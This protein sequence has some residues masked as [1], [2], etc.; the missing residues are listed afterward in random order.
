MIFD[1]VNKIDNKK[2]EAWTTTTPH[3]IAKRAKSCEM[4]HE[5]TLILNQKRTNIEVLDLKI[6][7][8]IVDGYKLTPAQLKK[9]QSQKYKKKRAK[10]LFINLSKIHPL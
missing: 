7:N 9:M 3:T 6:P 5:N 2:I 8:N 1:D 4:C 10:I